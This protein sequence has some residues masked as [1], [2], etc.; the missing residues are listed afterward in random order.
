MTAVY[1]DLVKESILIQFVLAGAGRALV[2]LLAINKFEATVIVEEI[3]VPF[4]MLVE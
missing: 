3:R 1:S 4:T 2:Y